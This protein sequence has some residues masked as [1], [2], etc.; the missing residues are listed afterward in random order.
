MHGQEAE[1]ELAHCRVN[2]KS[3]NKV[4]RTTAAIIDRTLTSDC[5]WWT[6]LA[7]SER[8]VSGDADYEGNTGQEICMKNLETLNSP[9]YSRRRSRKSFRRSDGGTQIA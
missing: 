1:F 2:V 3:G 6:D 4:M 9:G 7:A 8:P 5:A